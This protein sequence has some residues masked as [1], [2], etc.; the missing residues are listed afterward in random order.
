MQAEEQQRLEVFLQW[1]TR[2]LS[3][4]L[5]VGAPHARRHFALRGLHIVLSAFQ[6]DHWL[7][8][9]LDGGSGAAGEAALRV[10]LRRHGRDTDALRQLDT[11]AA[12]SARRF[13]PF[14]PEIHSAG[15]VQVR[16]ISQHAQ[17]AACSL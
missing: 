12:V 7:A 10:A 11:A 2:H 1:L 9:P 13:Q 3:D 16:S 5:Y 15:L 6:H 8:Q 4:S 14:A 17:R